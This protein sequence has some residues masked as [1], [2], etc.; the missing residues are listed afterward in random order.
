MSRGAARAACLLLAVIVCFHLDGSLAGPVTAPSILCFGDSLTRGG[1]YVRRNLQ[2]AAQEDWTSWAAKLGVSDPAQP[3]EQGKPQQQATPQGQAQLQQLPQQPQQLPQQ[4]QQLPQ[5]PQ[6]LPQRSQQLPQQPQPAGA[7]WPAWMP[8][9]AGAALGAHGMAG[10]GRRAGGGQ[11]GGQGMMGQGG[12][13]WMMGQGGGPDKG[14]GV[15]GQ[16]AGNGRAARMMARRSRNRLGMGR[17]F[18]LHPYSLQLAKLIKGYLNGTEVRV[19]TKGVQGERVCGEADVSPMA[20]RLGDLLKTRTE[21]TTDSNAAW[22]H[23]IILAGTN[24]LVTKKS[25]D[26]IIACLQTLHSLCFQ[27]GMRTLAVAIPESGYQTTH[28]A[29]RQK[30]EAVNEKLRAFVEQHKDMSAFA[31]LAAALPF[32]ASREDTAA[33][34]LWQMDGLHFSATGYDRMGEIIFD[35]FKKAWL[36]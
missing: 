13:Q 28:P 30:R 31:D 29:I 8:D 24:D 10:Q 25:S 1:V 32:P 14:Q 4:P 17:T 11:G 7:N 15:A 19:D 5:Q 21:G 33:W 12:G 9:K 34:S 36:S 16:G 23:A 27:A 26:D 2:E 22:T 20:A 3:Q 35:A 6:Q 18:E